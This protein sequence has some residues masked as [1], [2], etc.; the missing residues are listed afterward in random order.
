MAAATSSVPLALGI[1]RCRLLVG[2]ATCAASHGDGMEVP[3]QTAD[4]GGWRPQTCLLCRER[5]HQL[6][7]C[8][9]AAAAP[10]AGGPAAAGAAG[11][12]YNC[13]AAGHRLASCPDPPRG[14]CCKVC[15]KVSHLAKD[16]PGKLLGGATGARAGGSKKLQIGANGA[17]AT[18]AL[19]AG[20]LRHTFFASGDDL[21][22][23]FR[24]ELASNSGE[25]AAHDADDPKE[26]EGLQGMLESGSRSE[27]GTLGGG[28]GESRLDKQRRAT[29]TATKDLRA[30]KRLLET[31]QGSTATLRAARKQPKVVRF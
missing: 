5:G 9:R 11:I 16:C 7:D 21:E 4:G 1:P 25:L 20:G 22:D 28:V 29:S 12:C 19:P 27:E 6:K 17:A 23:D 30:V 8:P 3:R 26:E 13:G 10:S 2:A 18:T 15:G 24:E 14:G 31:K